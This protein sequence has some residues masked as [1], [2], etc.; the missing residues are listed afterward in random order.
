MAIYNY[1]NAHSESKTNLAD[2]YQSHTL[3]ANFIYQRFSNAIQIWGKEFLAF[4]L[5][6]DIH[7]SHPLLWNNVAS[8][9]FFHYFTYLLNNYNL[10][11][12][13]LELEFTRLVLNWTFIKTNKT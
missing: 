12:A 6:S 2:C 7:W 8:A 5:V 10:G 13:L 11:Y 4:M 1:G 3:V 9:L